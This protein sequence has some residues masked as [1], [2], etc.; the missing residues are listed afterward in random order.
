[1]GKYGTLFCGVYS[2]LE[3][4]ICSLIDRYHC[5]QESAASICRA[6]H[7]TALGSTETLLPTFKENESTFQVMILILMLGSQI[8]M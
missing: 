1:M 7:S 4:D 5:C 6:K 2:L 3:Y 8:P